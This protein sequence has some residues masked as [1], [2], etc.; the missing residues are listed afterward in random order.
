M[1]KALSDEYRRVSREFRALIDEAR[2]NSV[3]VKDPLTFP[4][5]LAPLLKNLN[6]F[7][8]ATG[9]E[10]LLLLYR[11]PE[12]KK[13]YSIWWRL[14]D[15][16]SDAESVCD[17]LSAEDFEQHKK[18]RDLWLQA[19]VF[20]RAVEAVGYHERVAEQRFAPL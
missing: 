2:I 4:A 11:L 16:Y 9:E 12:W 14:I 20:V 13:S 3:N 5:E 7:D 1:D 6:R 8:E 10:R 18:L 19:D 17:R 15:V